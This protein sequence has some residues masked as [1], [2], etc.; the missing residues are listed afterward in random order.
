MRTHTR[1]LHVPSRVCAF[2]WIDLREILSVV[3]VALASRFCSCGQ[4]PA[5]F[6][7]APGERREAVDPPAGLPAWMRARFSTG[8]GWPVRKPRPPHANPLRRDAQR[9]RTRGGLSLAYFSLATQREVGR[10]ARRADR[11]LL[12]FSFCSLLRA[13]TQS[14]QQVRNARRRAKAHPMVSLSTKRPRRST[15]RAV[16][17]AGRSPRSSLGPLGSGGRRSISPQGRRQG[18]RRG[19]RQARDGLSENPC[20]SFRPNGERID[21]GQKSRAG[22]LGE[23][24]SA[25]FARP[26]PQPLPRWERGSHQAQLRLS[27]VSAAAGSR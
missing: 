19:F 24:R 27:G 5:L 23:D 3:D 12:L 7:G 2:P 11:K 10:A 8:Q 15:P 14:K 22:I 25:R 18:C 17:L 1:Y 20:S 9:A 4:E 16:A 13:R 21:Q 6:D 26:P